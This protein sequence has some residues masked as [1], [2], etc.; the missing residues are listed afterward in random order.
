M[1]RKDRRYKKRGAVNNGRGQIS[2]RLGID[3]RPLVVDQKSRFGELETDTIVGKDHKGPIVTLKDRA[4]GTLKM[5]H[6]ET[7]EAIEVRIAIIEMLEE[8][9]PF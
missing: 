3:K 9:T 7:R 4:S 1:R 5:K 6:T 8:L 2:H